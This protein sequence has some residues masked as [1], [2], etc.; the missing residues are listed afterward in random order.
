M[1]IS[2]TFR[3]THIVSPYGRNDEMVF[4][5]DYNIAGMLE[6]RN[7]VRWTNKKLFRDLKTVFIYSCVCVWQ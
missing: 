7:G 4:S 3:L 5:C 2:N 6:G 1:D